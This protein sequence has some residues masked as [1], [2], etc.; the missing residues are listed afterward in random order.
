MSRQEGPW[1]FGRTPLTLTF[2]LEVA[3]RLC[4]PINSDFRSRLSI[5]TQYISEPK[6]LFV[7]PGLLFFQIFHLFILI[8]G[9]CFVPKP[10]IDVGVV[11]FIPRSEP[12][13]P[14]DFDVSQRF[15]RPKASFFLFL[16][17]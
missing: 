15:L 9:S 8:L 4:G 16:G 2:Q 13:I 10:E 5:V 3:N 6:I 7:I 12:L 14:C 11:K 1:Q 17:C